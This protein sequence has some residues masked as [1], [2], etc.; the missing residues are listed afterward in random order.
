LETNARATDAPEEAK[1]IVKVAE[2]NRVTLRLI[3]GLAIR[4]HCHGQHSTHLREYHDIDVFGLRKEYRGIHSVFQQLGYSPNEEYNLLCG[5]TR[6]QFIDRESRME[7]E[8]FLDKFRMGHTLDFRRRIQLD[9]LTI[10]ITDLLLTK[11]QVVQFAEKDAKDIVAILEDHELRHNDDRET[12]NLDY[13][14]RLCSQ[15]WGLYR[16]ITN[17]IATINESIG[18]E[19]SGLATGKELVERLAVIRNAL[20]TGKKGVRWRLRSLI[21]ERVRWYREVETGQG[22]AYSTSTIR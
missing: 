9:D 19:A 3:G 4:F 22:E 20:M 10:P 7:V 16:T 8:V 13:I 12:L 17:N 14:V 5:D 1:K 2:D 11:L 6:L 21:G 15:D 18:Q